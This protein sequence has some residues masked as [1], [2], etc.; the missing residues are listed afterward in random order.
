MRKVVLCAL[1]AGASTLARA[2]VQVRY[3]GGRVDLQATNAP[4]SEVLERLARATGM[5]VVHEGAPQRPT[6]TVTLP[7]RTPAEAVLGVLDG[8]GLNYAL[9]MDASGTKVDTLIITG[10]IPASSAAVPPPQIPAPTRFRPPQPEIPE[11]VE[12]ESLEPEDET[13]EPAADSRPPGVGARSARPEGTRP[14]DRE[15]Q[16]RVR[17]EETDEGTPGIPVA[18]AFPL[19]GAVRTGPSYPV[20]PFAPVPT[21]PFQQVS[22]PSQEPEPADAPD[23]AAE[24]PADEQ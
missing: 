18:P 22:P 16:R 24:E 5:K 21:S 1:F 6:V 2:E 17:D 14:R 20:S 23:D 10:A 15:A 13:V 12:D 9:K 19:P 11:D 3:Q 4:L 8:L 7:G